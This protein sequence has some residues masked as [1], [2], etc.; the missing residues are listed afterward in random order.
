MLYK[1][2]YIM[3]VTV[4]SF[5]LIFAS[6]KSSG[7]NASSLTKEKILM[8]TGSVLT[9]LSSLAIL[10]LYLPYVIFLSLGLILIHI[11]SVL[12]GF[13]LHGKLNLSHHIVKFVISGVIIFFFCYINLSQ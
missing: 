5:L 2:I 1:I 8:I 12:N 11:T 9:L 13:K 10:K 3:I 7:D 6:L 4:Y